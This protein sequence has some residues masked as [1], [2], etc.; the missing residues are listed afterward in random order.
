MNRLGLSLLCLLAAACQSPQQIK[1]C[2]QIPDGGCPLDRGGTCEDALCAALY[3]CY[4][5][6]W[7]R[8]EVCDQN[9]GGGGSGGGSTGTG[10]D[11]TPIQL[12]HTG[13]TTGCQPDLQL[14]D[15]P[16]AAAEQCPQN[17][18]LTDCIDFFLCK[19]EGWTALAYC[20]EEGMLIEAPR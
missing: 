18:C 1:L 16:V 14:P 13:E 11:C 9:T 6:V 19:A 8:E 20:D 4:D 3:G 15:C 10:G 2:G 17:A 7:V 12:D 5:G